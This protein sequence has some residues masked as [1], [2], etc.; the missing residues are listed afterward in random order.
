MIQPNQHVTNRKATGRDKNTWEEVIEA[1]YYL[2]M[3]TNAYGSLNE[4]P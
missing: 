4:N 1:F 2:D 3:V